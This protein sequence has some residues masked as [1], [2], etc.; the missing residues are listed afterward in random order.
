ML[1]GSEIEGGDVRYNERD[2]LWALRQGTDQY[3]A[4]ACWYNAEFGKHFFPEWQT[5]LFEWPPTTA[6]GA[7]SVAQWLSD[8]RDSKYQKDLSTIGGDPVPRHPKPWTGGKA[9]P[10]YGPPRPRARLRLIK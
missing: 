1:M 9:P 3:N 7:E 5:V 10:P 2:G 8:I 6:S 4:W